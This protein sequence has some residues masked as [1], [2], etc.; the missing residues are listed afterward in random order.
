VFAVPAIICGAIALRQMP[1][2]GERGHGMAIAGIILGILGVGYFLLIV[3][4]IVIGVHSS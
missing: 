4:L 2:A 3:L 1:A